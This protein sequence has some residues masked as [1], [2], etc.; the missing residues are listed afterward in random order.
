MNIRLSLLSFFVLYALATAYPQANPQH[1]PNSPVFK[2]YL[3]PLSIPLLEQSDATY[4]LWQGFRVMQEANAGKAVSQFELSVR[5]LTGRGFKPDTGR[6]AYWAARAAEQNHLLARFNLGIFQYNG[7]GTPWNPFEAY[8]NFLYVAE[9]YVPEAQHVVAQLLTENLVVSRNWNEAYRY[10]KAAADS[11]YAPAAAFLKELER[12]G[13]LPL[14]EQSS[15]AEPGSTVPP[16]RPQQ[17]GGMQLLLLDFTPDTAKATPDSILIADALRAAELVRNDSMF[18]LFSGITLQSGRP[19]IDSVTAARIEEFA[20]AGS[21]EAIT[22]LARLYETNGGTS[23]DIIRAA[24]LYHRA[25]RLDSRRASRLLFALMQEPGFFTILKSRVGSNDPVALYTWAGLIALGLDRQLTD[26]QALN[27]LERAH[28]AGYIPATIELAL[29]YY[30]GRWVSADQVKA[31][32]LLKE[33]AKKGSAEAA[34]R[35]AVLAVRGRRGDIRQEVEVL[36]RSTFAGSVLAQFAM[37]FCYDTG[38]GVE[39]DKGRAAQLY[40]ASGQ[41]G[42]QDAFRALERMYDEIRPS[43]VAFRIDR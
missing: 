19:L 15:T 23:R 28:T 10:A 30:A 31:G 29:A 9:R 7:W 42:S 16:Q 39:E 33:A 34:V 32:Q 4:Q 17:S 43:D 35:Q 26:G 11:G 22:L 27:M 40:I 14:P 38:T 6:A 8:K 37:G 18:V 5:Y 21:P 13:Y 1:R 25:V 36:Q 24:A 2:S 41:R 20:D 3:P 12:R